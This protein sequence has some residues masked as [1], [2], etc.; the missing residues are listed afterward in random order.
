MIAKGGG[1]RLS[2]IKAQITSIHR[3]IPKAENGDADN[4][5]SSSSEPEPILP[6]KPRVEKIT[7]TEPE[8][9]PPPPRPVK[10]IGPL[11]YEETI[12]LLSGAESRTISAEAQ[13]R[14]LGE[15]HKGA[16]MQK[17]CQKLGVDVA[18]FKA[19]WGS[20]IRLIEPSIL[21]A[22]VHLIVVLSHQAL[23]ANRAAQPRSG[24]RSDRL[25]FLRCEYH[26][27]RQGRTHR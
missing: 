16:D 13:L 17:A 18:A 12:T 7:I 15:L 20:F 27:Y 25:R 24:L 8:R 4:D 19:L 21:D 1:A 2:D 3:F 10:P 22:S 6:E 14:I 23:R 9:R 26:A 11:W 5:S